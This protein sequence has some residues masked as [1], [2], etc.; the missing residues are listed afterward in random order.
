MGVAAALVAI[1]PGVTVLL[2]AVVLQER[3]TRAQLVGF[4]LG[5]G[6]IIFISG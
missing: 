4:G 2:A 1:F 6:G 5:A 3:I